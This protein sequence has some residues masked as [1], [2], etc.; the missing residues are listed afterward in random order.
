[1]INKKED[2]LESI[3]K[4]QQIIQEFDREKAIK[5][6]IDNRAKHMDLDN[7]T[8][9]IYCCG[10]TVDIN[11]LPDKVILDN[12]KIQIFWLSDKLTK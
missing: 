5:Q 4:T 7:K 1:M 12:L 6:Y 11:S 10:D 8:D 9:Q 3:I 2:I